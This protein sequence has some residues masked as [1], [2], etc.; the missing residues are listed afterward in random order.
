MPDGCPVITEHNPRI[1]GESSLTSAFACTTPLFAAAPAGAAAPMVRVVR[2][3]CG[4]PLCRRYRKGNPPA[5]PALSCSGGIAGAWH[6]LSGNPQHAQGLMTGGTGCFLAASCPS[7]TPPYSTNVLC[8]QA[9]QGSPGP[10]GMCRMTVSE[11]GPMADTNGWYLLAC[12]A[13]DTDVP[14]TDYTFSTV[15]LYSVAA[16]STPDLRVRPASRA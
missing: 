8:L 6:F 15:C 10:P 9:E 14:V 11:S 13:T 2:K 1:S 7:C 16:V 12:R 5:D 3:V 4:S